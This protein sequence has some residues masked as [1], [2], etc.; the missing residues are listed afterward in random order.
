MRFWRRVVSLSVPAFRPALSARSFLDEQRA[1]SDLDARG[2]TCLRPPQ[3]LPRTLLLLLGVVI[4]SHPRAKLDAF[5]TRVLIYRPH[6]AS[7]SPRPAYPPSYHPFVLLRAVL[8][9]STPPLLG[10]HLPWP[11]SPKAPAPITHCRLFHARPRSRTSA[12]R[13]RGDCS[14]GE[15]PRKLAPVVHRLSLRR[16]AWFRPLVCRVRVVSSV[17]LWGRSAMRLL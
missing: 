15:W 11:R 9:P 4:P 10:P 12:G 17:L 1:L 14:N 5:H 6:Y 2:R 7:C 3:F 16:Y 13:R 8:Q